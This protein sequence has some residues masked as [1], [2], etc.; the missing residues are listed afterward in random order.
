MGPKGG[1]F[2]VLRGGKRYLPGEAKDYIQDVTVL[3]EVEARQQKGRPKVRG[4]AT[5][6]T[7]RAKSTTIS[8]T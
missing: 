3:A 8:R 4:A 5:S 6:V 7:F 1:L 2:V